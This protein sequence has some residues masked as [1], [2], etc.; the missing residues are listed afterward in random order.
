MTQQE[1]DIDI[2]QMTSIYFMSCQANAGDPTGQCR[3]LR[4]TYQITENER[5]TIF[6]LILTAQGQH[7]SGIKVGPVK[8]IPARQERHE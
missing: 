2:F 6:L 3:L 4:Q 5:Q 1:T 7:I 8:T